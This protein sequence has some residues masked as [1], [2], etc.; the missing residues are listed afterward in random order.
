MILIATKK[1]CRTWQLQL[2]FVGL[3]VVIPNKIP[4]AFLESRVLVSGVHE[5]CLVILLLV[6]VFPLSLTSEE[7]CFHGAASVVVIA[8]LLRFMAEGGDGIVHLTFFSASLSNELA[9]SA[10]PGTVDQFYKL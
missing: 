1:A 10:V 7:G 6:I 8:L 3:M 9:L 2:H 4:A 5:V